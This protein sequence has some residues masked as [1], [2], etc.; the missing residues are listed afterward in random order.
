MI[1]GKQYKFD[2]AHFL[3]GHPKCGK[4]HGHTWTVEV[5]LF[6]RVNAEGMV[7]DFNHLND[8]V[9]RL[10]EKFDHCNLNELVNRPTCE[11]IATIIWSA[12]VNE[13]QLPVYQV[14]VQEG[15]GGWARIVKTSKTS[16]S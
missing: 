5:E 7:Y 16:K 3:P 1:I 4:M 8:A 12:L 15:A 9:G 14:K 10:F 13:Y 11:V 6:G 2:A